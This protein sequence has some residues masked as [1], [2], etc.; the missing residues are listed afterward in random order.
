MIIINRANSDCVALENL[1]IYS[2]GGNAHERHL[3]AQPFKSV[4]L[5]AVN[6]ALG[7]QWWKMQ[8]TKFE[9]IDCLQ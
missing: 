4:K 1:F 7:V 2:N 3:F 5:H 9:I 6:E 8:S